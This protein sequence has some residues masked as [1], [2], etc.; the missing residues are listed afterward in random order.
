MGP[1]VQ[2]DGAAT[3]PPSFFNPLYDAAREPPSESISWKGVQ[4]FSATTFAQS[5]YAV[6]DETVLFR[7]ARPLCEPLLLMDSCSQ[8]QR[9]FLFGGLSAHFA[10]GHEDT[11]LLSGLAL[12]FS[13]AACLC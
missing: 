6:F 12:A 5:E 4:T 13:I 3:G 9:D 8:S 10:V 1:G 2:F 11:R 7:D